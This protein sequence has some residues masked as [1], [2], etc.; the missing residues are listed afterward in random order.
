METLSNCPICEST[1]HKIFLS[2]K[3]NS[4]SK[5]DFNIIE[6]DCCGFKYTNPRPEENKIGKYYQSE[7]YVSHN[8]S[9]KGF[10]NG[11]YQLV[12]KYTLW[13]K[14]NLM[15]QISGKKTGKLLDYGCGTGDF[16][17]ILQDV[18][19]EVSGLEP[20]EGA[21]KLAQN[22]VGEARVNDLSKLN[23]LDNKYDVITCWHVVEHIHELNSTLE[24]LIAAMHPNGKLVIAVPNITSYDSL[25]YKEF[26]A[27]LDV[28]RHLYHFRP[29]DIENL[30][31]NH[32]LKLERT[33]PMV[34]DSFYVSMLSEKYKGGSVV[35]AFWM[36]LISNIKAAS[37]GNNTYSSQIYILKTI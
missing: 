6:C 33:L 26:W 2:V 25:H 23:S 30:A 3:D 1:K 5:E 27:A 14:L 7:E 36:G 18:K 20:D 8:D 31:K 32:G 34:F 12:K 10:I 17:K 16:I 29:S 13:K 21:R 4:V 9:N 24:K 37:K 35:K 28:P 22:K 11:I 15:V 19:W